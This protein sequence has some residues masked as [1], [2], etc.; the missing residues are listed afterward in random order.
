MCGRD[1]GNPLG[2]ALR[3]T[4]AEIKAAR[5]RLGLTQSGLARALRL[6][7]K[8]GADTVRFWES[9]RNPISGP[10]IV[11]IELMLERL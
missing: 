2:S 6:S 11:A 7:E 10:A 4:P 1:G 5:K 8:S 9:G 3:M